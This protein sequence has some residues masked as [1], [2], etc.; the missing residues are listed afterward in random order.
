MTLQL[1]THQL[2]W[3]SLNLF[4]SKY[5]FQNSA[6]CQNFLKIILTRYD[7]L[8]SVSEIKVVISNDQLL[9]TC[10]KKRCFKYTNICIAGK[11]FFSDIEKR[12]NNGQQ[13]SISR[14]FREQVCLKT[15]LIWH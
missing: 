9:T 7:Q 13:M 5:H 4:T 1:V 3:A 8:S 15:P 10:P 14:S 6:I 12:V 2:H 11:V